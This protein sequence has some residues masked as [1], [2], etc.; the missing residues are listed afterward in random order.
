MVLL[1]FCLAVF[2][3]YSRGSIYIS[4]I[5]AKF[6]GEMRILRVKFGWLLGFWALASVSGS[7]Y[8]H[9]SLIRVWFN[10][11]LKGCVDAWFDRGAFGEFGSIANKTTHIH[12]LYVSIIV[13]VCV[14]NFLVRIIRTCDICNKK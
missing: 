2:P 5:L 9:V 1:D 8:I 7:I 10:R 3:P 4:K 11:G 13:F 6:L 12:I 14:Y